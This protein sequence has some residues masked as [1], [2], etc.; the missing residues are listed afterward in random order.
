MEN[1]A[2]WLGQFAADDLSPVERALA[3]GA[4][5]DR[6][7]ESEAQREQAEMDAAAADR[8]EALEVANHQA[9]DPLGQLQL[10]RARLTAADD[11]VRDLADQLRRAEAKRAGAEESTRYWADRLAPVVESMQRHEIRDPVEL[12][13]RR[14]HQ[15]FVAVTRERLAA[16]SA[17]RSSRPF[18]RGFAVGDEPVTC[19][20]CLAIGA[21]PEE[22]FA[23]HHMTDDGHLLSVDPAEPVGVPDDGERSA[24]LGYGVIHR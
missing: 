11:R 2:G 12:A 7:E 17:V 14:A 1:A 4:M 22:S 10:A 13:T 21:T 20:D 9:G 24:P 6:R 8:R 5:Q 15:E 3:L 23:I 18:G 16:G 19:P